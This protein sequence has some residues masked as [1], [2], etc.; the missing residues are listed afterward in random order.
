MMGSSQQKML[1][2]FKFYDI[3][4]CDCISKK[5]VEMVLQHITKVESSSRYGIS[6]EKEG[7]MAKC[8][9][10]DLALK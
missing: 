2:A 1:I 3:E 9:R 6:F 4:Q 5:D 10:Y 7:N 8:S